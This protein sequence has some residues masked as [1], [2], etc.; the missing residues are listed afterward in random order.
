MTITELRQVHVSVA[1]VVAGKH[2]IESARGDPDEYSPVY[3]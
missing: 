1:S 3:R 2:Y